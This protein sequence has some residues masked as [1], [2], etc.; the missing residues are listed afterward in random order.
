M[1]KY[2][3]RYLDKKES[4]TV[5]ILRGLKGTRRKDNVVRTITSH[6]SITYGEKIN[7]GDAEFF[8]NGEKVEGYDPLHWF[9][10]A[11]QCVSET[12]KV[13]GHDVIVRLADLTNIQTKDLPSW[14]KNFNASAGGY[15]Y[16]NGRLIKGKVCKYADGS[17]GQFFPRHP[18][19]RFVRWAVYYDGEID[20]VMN[21]SFD[22]TTLTPDSSVLDKIAA[23]IIPDAKAVY[24]ATQIKKKNSNQD[25]KDL[26][27]TATELA[28]RKQAKS[29]QIEPDESNDTVGKLRIVEKPVE[30]EVS[31]VNPKLPKY[32]VTEQRLGALNE[33]WIIEI[34]PDQT[35]SK[36][37]LRLNLDHRY[38][39][40]FWTN[41]D[42]SHRDVV[43]VTALST[44]FANLE[45]AEDD[46]M[47]IL[48]YRGKV[49][50]NLNK[51]T[52]IL[53]KK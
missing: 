2:L 47:D 52:T 17:F 38:I 42:S 14:A 34:N 37:I 48:D 3:D 22:K 30:P 12:I 19:Y 50:R 29:I 16:R 46:C 8:V 28:R 51:T 10:G 31:E 35:Q 1:D 6:C 40:T 18:D 11:T 24:K 21:V 20:D 33:P 25:L 43:K 44:C 32:H 39:S 27:N 9:S 45:I 23:T 49:S 7:V 15:F 5:I 4:V 53:S 41:G 13:N 36:W 26:E